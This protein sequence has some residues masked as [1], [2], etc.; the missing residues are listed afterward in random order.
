MYSRRT[1]ILRALAS[2]YELVEIA[3]GDLRYLEFLSD[4]AFQRNAPDVLDSVLDVI[5]EL[6]DLIKTILG[7]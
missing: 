3:Q 6:D 4:E 7:E 2:A 1:E 5:E